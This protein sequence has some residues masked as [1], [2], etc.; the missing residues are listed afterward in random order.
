MSYSYPEVMPEPMYQPPRGLS[1]TAKVL[2]IL[3]VLAG[4]TLVVCCGV[5][6]ALFYWGKRSFA[7]DPQEVAAGT[8]E[9]ADITIPEP[10]LPSVLMD[11]RVPFTGRR[12]MMMAFY[13]HPETESSITLMGFDLLADEQQR[14]EIQRSME[15][16]ARQRSNEQGREVVPAEAMRHAVTIGGKDV[17]FSILRVKTSDGRQRVLAA[18]EFPGRFGQATLQID[19]DES[20][21]PKEKLETLLNSIR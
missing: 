4:A 5:A 13:H 21:L 14:R 7:T 12:L 20:V 16:A 19:A 1:G 2:I 9:I 10:F 18:G 8:R 17:E 15:D 11:M 6:G 3:G